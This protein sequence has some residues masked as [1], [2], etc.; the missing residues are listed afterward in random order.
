MQKVYLDYAAAT[1]VLLEV[2]QAMLPYSTELFYNPSA[3]YAS[4]LEVHE[5]IEKARADIAHWLGGR[6]EEIIFTSGAT[7]ANNLA[8]KGVLEVYPGSKVLISAIE[9]ESVINP[10]QEYNCESIAVTSDG[11]INLSDLEQKIDNDTVLVSILYANNEI[12]TIQDLRAI[13]GVLQKKL[14]ARQKSGNKLPLLLHTDAAQAPSYLDLHVHAL[15]VDLM[16][17]NSGKIYGPK[18]MGCLYVKRGLVLKPLLQGGGQERG[19]RSS[20]ENAGGIIGFAAALQVVQESREDEVAR[21]EKLRDDLIAKLQ[22]MGGE[23]N[24][25]TRHRLANNV[26]VTFPGQ[27]N[28]RLLFAL[29]QKGFMVAAGSACSASK[30]EPSH[31]LKAIGL[32]DEQAQAS[33][34]ITLGRFTA[35]DE[36]DSLVTTLHELLKLPTIKA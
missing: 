7:E 17:L 20:T 31:V 1:P 5:A 8:I 33:L 36:L 21:L 25:S 12:G 13:S 29:D 3:L 34:R 35:Q 16:T 30:D 9:H 24:G 10:A 14:Q 15:G 2:V 11:R 18:G 22:K 28:E 6:K 32:S 4:A 23:I 19:F 26:H 27:D